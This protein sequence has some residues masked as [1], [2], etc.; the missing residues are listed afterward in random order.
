VRNL[1]KTGHFL[2]EL[3]R[4]YIFKNFVQMSSRYVKISPT[5]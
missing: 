4:V 2:K 1:I 5:P 3:G